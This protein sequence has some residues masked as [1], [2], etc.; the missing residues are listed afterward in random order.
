MTWLVYEHK[1]GN[2]YQ[3]HLL[4]HRDHPAS[5]YRWQA[6]NILINTNNKIMLIKNHFI[7]IPI[8]TSKIKKLIQNNQLPIS[9]EIER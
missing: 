2:N 1:L 4:G 3:Q 9:R 5:Q 6:R 8:A 7:K